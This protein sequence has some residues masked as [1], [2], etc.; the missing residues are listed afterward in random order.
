MGTNFAAQKNVQRNT[1]FVMVNSDNWSQWQ[2]DDESYQNYNSKTSASQIMI[3]MLTALH[4]MHNNWC[5][6]EST[7]LIHIQCVVM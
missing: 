7:V 5:L 2:T 3:N 4:T 1:N 6:I